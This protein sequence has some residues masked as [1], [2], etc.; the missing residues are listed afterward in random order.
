MN[1][2]RPL[3][4]EVFFYAII[5]NNKYKYFKI[6]YGTNDHQNSASASLEMIALH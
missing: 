5:N 1:Y 6:T 2:D 4:K 3:E